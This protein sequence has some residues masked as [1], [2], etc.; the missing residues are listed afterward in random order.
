MLILALY[1]ASS[2]VQALLVVAAVTLLVITNRRVRA[3]WRAASENPAA[4]ERRGRRD[5]V[6]GPYG[7]VSAD[8]DID[9]P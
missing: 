8:P 6:M 1:D 3:E 7:A 5:F 2:A 9:R 4:V